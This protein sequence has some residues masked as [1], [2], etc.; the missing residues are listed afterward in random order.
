VVETE[1]CR[2]VPASSDLDRVEVRLKAALHDIRQPLATVFALAECIR[3]TPDLPAEAFGWLDRLVDQVQ[4]TADAVTSALFTGGATAA[5]VSSLRLDEVVDSVLQSFALTWSGRLISS[6]APD[7]IWVHGSWATVRRCVVNLVENAV[8]AAG[9]D[10]TVVVTLQQG[11]DWA[12]VFVDDDGPG[13]GRVPRG[14]GIGLDGTLRSVERLGGSL[15]VGL[16]AKIGGARVVLS[17][18]VPDSG[19]TS[20]VGIGVG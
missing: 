18:P 20:R 19:F 9:P 5:S 4:E 14:S 15:V 7:S 8:R 17:L 2:Q 11:P 16:R 10:G 13:F 1:Q 12:R 3:S 6:G